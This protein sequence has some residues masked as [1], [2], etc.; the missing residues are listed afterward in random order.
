MPQTE[1]LSAKA[2]AKQET[3]T[4]VAKATALAI[5]SLVSKA[6]MGKVMQDPELG[7]Q[8]GF[9]SGI[10]L[11]VLGMSFDAG[12]NII[13]SLE[14]QIS[15]FSYSNLIRFALHTFNALASSACALGSFAGAAAFMGASMEQSTMDS[16]YLFPLLLAIATLRALSQKSSNPYIKK[17]GETAVET[18]LSIIAGATVGETSGQLHEF[19]SAATALFTAM[20]MTKITGLIGGFFMAAPAAPVPTTEA[21]MPMLDKDSEDSSAQTPA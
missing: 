9:G 18:G 6:I 3:A 8:F 11:S 5:P 10:A 12:N 16:G 20:A 15:E 17:L 21:E 2:T 13:A 19:L 4:V 7:V 1:K 14:E